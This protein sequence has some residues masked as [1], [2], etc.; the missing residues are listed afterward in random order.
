MGN[1]LGVRHCI[2]YPHPSVSIGANQNTGGKCRGWNSGGEVK[3]KA[4]GSPICK[5]TAPL[6]PHRRFSVTSTS[7]VFEIFDISL[8]AAADLA[9]YIVCRVA[10]PKMY[11]YLLFRMF[12]CCILFVLSFVCA[13]LHLFVLTWGQL[14]RFFVLVEVLWVNFSS[15]R[16]GLWV[17]FYFNGL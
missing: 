16:K 8:C 10:S 7:D 11:L 13:D 12:F 5:Y 6:M 3:W 17:L 2:T 1:N 4:Y 15:K 9:G 14:R